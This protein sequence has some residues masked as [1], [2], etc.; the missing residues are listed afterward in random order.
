MITYYTIYESPIQPIMLTSNGMAL[1][2]LYLNQHRNGPENDA[3]WICDPEIAPFP[4]VREQLDAYFEGKLTIFDVPLAPRGTDFQQRVWQEL[5]HIPCGE[6]IS[7]GELARRIGSPNAS[8][9]VG[10]ANSRNP[11]S[12]IVPCHR[13]VGAN[14]K[15]T[16]YAGGISSK[17]ALLKLEASHSTQKPLVFKY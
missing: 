11:I 2:G 8:R 12:I 10:L 7:Y 14:G 1:T 17:E 13:V 6:T 15:M 4:R 16:G 5:T 3:D 9:A